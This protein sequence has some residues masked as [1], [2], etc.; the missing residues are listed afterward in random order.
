MRYVV[1]ADVVARYPAL[2]KAS[3]AEEAKIEDNF[4]AGSESEVDAA[5][6]L[7]YSVPLSSTP[8]LA[9]RLVRDITM[10][11][12]YYKTSLLQ[13]DKDQSSRLWDYIQT[14]LQGIA[15]G[16]LAL[17]VSGS[18]VAPTALATAYSTTG[19]NPN[20]TGMDAAE[21]WR[22]SDQELDALESV[23]QQ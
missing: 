9:P 13:L 2:A 4:I 10:D 19:T 21:E 23:R 6:A 5:I 8:T 1:W 3:Q 11:L 22:V 14:R 17:V 16:S 18:V 15:C 12:V 7:R 20:V